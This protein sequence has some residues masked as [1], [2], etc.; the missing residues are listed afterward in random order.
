MNIFSDR[1]KNRNES[2]KDPLY[3][4][5]F[6]YGKVLVDDEKCMGCE[7]CIQECLVGA[8]MKKDRIMIDSLN[9]IFCGECI[10]VC[11]NNALRMSNDYKL[12]QLFSTGEE[13]K[14]KIFKK[15]NRSLALRSVDTGSCNACMLELAATQNNFYSLSRYG[16]QFAASPRH[17]DGIVVTGPVSIN[18]KDALLKTYKAMPEPKFVIAVG[19]CAHE[20]G[21]FK[22][23]YG[24]YD[25]L[26]NLLPVDI[27]IPGCPPSP[28]AIIDG[29]L[30]LVDRI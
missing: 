13:L 2:A 7:C 19:S 15:F 12:A 26:K 3:D 8:I 4:N 11:P 27:T 18:M 14:K 23:A 29:L 1:I 5:K 30:K 6:S 21:V 24:N 25:S 10:D 16:I 17:C 9:C 28:Q 22:D 20:G